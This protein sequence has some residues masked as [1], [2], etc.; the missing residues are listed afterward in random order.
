M[1]TQS[2]IK[3]RREEQM[4]MVQA[5]RPSP[6][7]VH[8]PFSN[9]PKHLGQDRPKS[10]AKW[11]SVQYTDPWHI[12]RKFN[13]DDGI[14]ASTKHNRTIRASLVV[15]CNS[16]HP[17]VQVV[18]THNPGADSS[19][20]WSYNRTVYTFDLTERKCICKQVV[21]N[22]PYELDSSTT[23]YIKDWTPSPELIT[24][25]QSDLLA[26]NI[27]EYIFLRDIVRNFWIRGRRKHRHKGDKTKDMD[28]IIYLPLEIVD[29]ILSY[30]DQNCGFFVG[31]YM[32]VKR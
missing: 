7:L 14:K 17:L 11:V 6:T 22:H 23:V 25:V 21:V 26:H 1:K 10:V 19:Y 9:Y 5:A 18:I 4:I 20:S 30:I 13:L 27:R 24:R 31:P 3:K 8:L 2:R 16:V 28:F 12:F 32:R 29:I 15:Q